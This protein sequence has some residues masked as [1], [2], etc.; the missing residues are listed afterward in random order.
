MQ[1]LSLS[2]VLVVACP[3]LLCPLAAAQLDAANPAMQST[4]KADKAMLNRLIRQVRRID[5]DT[6]AL[7]EKAMNEARN[8]DGSAEAVTKAQLLSL[9]DERDRLF[10]RMF[11]LSIRHGWAIPDIDKPTASKANRKEAHDSVFGAIDTLVNRRFAAEAK[12]IAAT[13][14]MPVVS[15]KSME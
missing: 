1:R 13:L 8:N 15:L 5:R 9:R 6:E 4:Q 3:L 7:M 12:R 2:L 10:S 14:S 11:I